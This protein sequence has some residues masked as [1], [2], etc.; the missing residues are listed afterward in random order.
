[1]LKDAVRNSEL[2]RSLQRCHELLLH[3][4]PLSPVHT[5]RTL[6][7]KLPSYAHQK[8]QINL[9][10]CI[11]SCMQ[12]FVPLL[13]HQTKMHGKLIHKKNSIRSKDSSKI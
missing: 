3:G 13:L 12:F 11:Y 4:T 10:T 8:Y 6:A 7:A 9:H 2:S 5:L 1:M